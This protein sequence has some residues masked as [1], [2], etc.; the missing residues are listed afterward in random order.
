MNMRKFSSGSQRYAKVALE[1]DFSWIEYFPWACDL[2][3]VPPLAL[4]TCL[5]VSVCVYTC[6]RGKVQVTQVSVCTQHNHS[7]TF[8]HTQGKHVSSRAPS[9]SVS[10][11]TGQIQVSRF[12]ELSRVK[13]DHTY[14]TKR[15]SIASSAFRCTHKTVFDLLFLFLDK[16]YTQSQAVQSEM[17]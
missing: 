2:G 4:P 11:E 3:S 14:R 17:L 8:W 7:V 5:T 9:E 1:P 6:T 12:I 13:F 15:P 16:V 10:C